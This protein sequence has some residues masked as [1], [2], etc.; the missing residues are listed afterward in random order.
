MS[1]RVTMRDVA[2]YKEPTVLE[3]DKKVTLIY[4]LNGAGKSTLS[5]YL[6]DPDGVRF[7][8]C[9]Q[10]GLTLGQTSVYNANFVRDNFYEIDKLNGIFTLSKTNKD[11]EI[12]IDRKDKEIQSLKADKESALAS[13]TAKNKEIATARTNAE[14]LTWKIK[15]AYS[16][17]DRVLE[18]CLRGYM[19]AKGPLFDFISS[20]PLSEVP[21]TRT[22]T[23]LKEEV[24]SL[25]ADNARAYPI[26]DKINREHLHIEG[27]DIFTQPIVGNKDS[28]IAGLIDRLGLTLGLS[29][30][31]FCA[32]TVTKLAPSVKQRQ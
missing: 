8:R 30:W 17:G 20:L 7:S 18:Y 13:I 24:E 27:N 21:S 5:N 16:G 4:G 32:P 19:K 10:E 14:D 6:Y 25:Q 12:A 2:S 1:F 31:I 3:S 15:T 23:M 29:T 28:P 11:V 9:T 26:I 22:I